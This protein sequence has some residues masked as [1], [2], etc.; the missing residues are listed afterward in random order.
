VQ[1]TEDGRPRA[2]LDAEIAVSPE[3]SINAVVQRIV[4][5]SAELTGAADAALGGSRC[6]ELLGGR[7]I[8]RS[9]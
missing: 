3:L 6:G 4:E 9:G 2:L 5:A 7:P 1:Q 8:M